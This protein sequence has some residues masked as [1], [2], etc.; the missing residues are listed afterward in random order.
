METPTGKNFDQLGNYSHINLQ[1][2]Q[3]KSDPEKI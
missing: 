3:V 1:R 2:R